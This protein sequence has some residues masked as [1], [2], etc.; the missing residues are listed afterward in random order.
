MFLFVHLQSVRKLLFVF[1]MKVEQH[2]DSAKDASKKIFTTNFL[3]FFC[4]CC[5][6][7]VALYDL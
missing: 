5:T 1:V 4:C 3:I 7:L 2:D 6:S